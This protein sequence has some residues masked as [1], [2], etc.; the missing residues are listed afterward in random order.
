MKGNAE[1][2]SGSDK[3]R[4]ACYSNRCPSH[5]QNPDGGWI[6][7][8]DR[9]ISGISYRNAMPIYH[10]ELGCGKLYTQRAADY[11]QAK[12]SKIT[13]TKS[14]S[15]CLPTFS[16]SLSNHMAL[17]CPSRDSSHYVRGRIL[18]T[19]TAMTAETL[20]STRTRL[21]AISRRVTSA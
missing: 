15:F 12:H 18:G 16:K 10:D 21:R 2:S 4:T 9:C 11:M 20:W 17:L 14:R 5:I 6:V 19:S 3:K 1:Q 13:S 7:T 8:Q